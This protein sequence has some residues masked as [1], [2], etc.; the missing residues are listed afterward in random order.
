MCFK[1]F[2]A[3]L[4]I[5]IYLNYVRITWKKISNINYVLQKE[6]YQLFNLKCS[7]T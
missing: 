6:I 2:S 5:C 1:H 3:N 4:A 7:N